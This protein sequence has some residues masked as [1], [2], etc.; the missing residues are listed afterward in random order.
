MEI[1]LTLHSLKRFANHHE[2]WFTKDSEVDTISFK[3]LL[4]ER[5]IEIYQY[6]NIVNSYN[7][8]KEVR[9]WK[10]KIVFSEEVVWIYK[11]ITYILYDEHKIDIYKQKERKRHDKIRKRHKSKNID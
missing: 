10:E 8:R 6:W 5:F 7:W 2:Y 4:R 3:K 1:I 9:L 11:I